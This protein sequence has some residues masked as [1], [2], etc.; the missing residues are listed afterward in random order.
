M[1][2]V[3]PLQ[4]ARGTAALAD[5]GMLR[6]PHLVSA[7]RVGFDKPWEPL[8]QPA[9]LRI[10]ESPE[11]LRVVQEGMEMTVHGPGGTARAIST[12]LQYRMA[13]KTGTAQVVN[14]SAMAVNPKSLPLHRR[15]RA[16]FIGYAPA[17]DPTI[18]VAV[19]V[20]GG[21]YGGATAAPI[22]R[23]ILDA[24]LLG[25][26]PEN[27]IDDAGTSTRIVV[28]TPPAPAVTPPVVPPATATP[29]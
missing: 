5:H 21:G 25:T 8:P 22:A 13:G 6:R 4:L 23:K 24:W 10:T 17:Q 12:G 1:W 18:A 28:G 20:E 11:H 14:R 16:L 19:M 15:H 26:Q 7:R 9:P 27:G 3:T 29:P 2:K